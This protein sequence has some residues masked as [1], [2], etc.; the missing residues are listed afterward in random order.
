MSRRLEQL[1]PETN[2]GWGAKLM[3]LDQSMR[4]DTRQP[5]LMLF[6][7]VIFVLLI[8][9]TNVAVLLLTRNTRRRKELAV[10]AALEAADGD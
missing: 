5:F 3:S 7:A 8:A 6:G 1:H 9:C 4:G 2:T 10:R